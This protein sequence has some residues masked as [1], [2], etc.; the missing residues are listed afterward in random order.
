MRG[1]LVKRLFEILCVAFALLL[2][3]S[4]GHSQE[5]PD[6]YTKIISALGAE[7]GLR[8]FA[9]DWVLR[10][11]AADDTVV[12]GMT[13]SVLQKDVKTLIEGFRDLPPGANP[14]TSEQDVYR[15]IGELTDDSYIG[16]PGLKSIV[17]NLFANEPRNE[18]GALLALRVAADQGLAAR[19]AVGSGSGFEQVIAAS[20]VERRMDL[21][22]HDPAAPSAL[23]G[24]SWEIKN[25]Y[26]GLPQSN[27][28]LEAFMDEFRRDVLIHASTNFEWYRLSFREA[29]RPHL[30]F[31][32]A[33]LVRQFDDPVVAAAL[34]DELDNVRTAFEAIWDLGDQG[35]LLQ[36]YP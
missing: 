19:L 36:F 10:F 8:E 26:L 5:C 30:P 15:A 16:A 1:A 12:R 6:L 18:L 20:G 14:F 31:L 7:P 3:S 2:V 28:T 17:G 34:G 32:R 24:T 27:S 4:E 9:E 25:W 13:K 23:G 29:T 33:E 35:D 11:W 22:L 21:R